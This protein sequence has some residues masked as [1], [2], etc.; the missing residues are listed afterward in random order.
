MP[1]IIVKQ[2]VYFGSLDSGHSDRVN[3]TEAIGHA[4]TVGN[5]KTINNSEAIGYTNTVLTGFLSN[6]LLGGSTTYHA[7]RSH[8]AHNK[9]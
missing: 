6:F 7:T 1:F 8:Q 3:H 4:N 2:L 5:A 9:E